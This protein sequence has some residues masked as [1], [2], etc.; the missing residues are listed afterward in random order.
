MMLLDFLLMFF[1]Q[2]NYFLLERGVEIIG[3]KKKKFLDIVQE[4]YI[5]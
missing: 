3:Y 1:N 2:L 4:L 5:N